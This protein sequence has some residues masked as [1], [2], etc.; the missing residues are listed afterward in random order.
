MDKFV[1]LEKFDE[2]YTD[3]KQN[4]ELMVHDLLNYICKPDADMIGVDNR[5]RRLYNVLG[6]MNNLQEYYVADNK[7]KDDNLN[8]NV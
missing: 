5:L 8:I 1:T 4:Q 2:K 7:A 3:L 6:L